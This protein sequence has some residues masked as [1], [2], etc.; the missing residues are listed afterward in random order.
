MGV[1]TCLEGCTPGCTKCCP[2]C[3]CPP[4]YAVGMLC[5]RAD[6][7]TPPSCSAAAHLPVPR[8]S[9]P[10]PAD[11]GPHPGGKAQRHGHERPRQQREARVLEALVLPQ[12]CCPVLRL[13]AAAQ[14]ALGR[15]WLWRGMLAALVAYVGRTPPHLS[16]CCNARYFM[17]TPS[18]LPLMS[19]QVTY[20]A[21]AMETVPRDIYDDCH[22]YQVGTRWLVLLACVCCTQTVQQLG[23]Q[24]GE[25]AACFTAACCRSTLCEGCSVGPGMDY[26]GE[27]LGSAALPARLLTQSVSPC[28]LEQLE[29]DY[30]AE[31]HG[32]DLV[33]SLASRCGEPVLLARL[34][35]GAA[36]AVWSCAAGR[37]AVVCT[38]AVAGWP[39]PQSW[40]RLVW[41]P[42]MPPPPHPPPRLQTRLRCSHPTAP[43]PALCPLCT[44]CAAARETRWRSWC[45]AAP[46]GARERL[47]P[48]PVR[49]AW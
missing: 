9:T 43:A 47:S 30:K 4:R 39:P 12:C 34:V 36:R 42:P 18:R 33:E 37:P 10:S 32:G 31:C 5:R 23:R 29:I 14:R 15:G 19:P 13:C 45:A 26:Q 11:C 48:H 27:C 38:A 40:L 41:L 16:A 8:Q 25:T 24:R 3:S 35:V 6:G 21:W 46:R 2:T 1:S 22:L 28:S 49:E 44:C 20:L 7:R 17:P